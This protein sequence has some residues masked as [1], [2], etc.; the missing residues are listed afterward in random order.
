MRLSLVVA[1]ARNGVI[2]REGQLPWRLPAD[3]RYFRRLT[4]GHPVVM[5][6]ITHESI[7]RALP[8][9]RNVV[10]TRDASRVA[11]GCESAHSLV[12]ALYLLREVPEVM[13][14]GGRALYAEALPRADRLY[15]TEVQ[16]AV[17]GDV[18]FPDFD[19]AAF[20]EISREEHAPEAG[21]DYP[22]TFLTLERIGADDA[23]R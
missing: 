15:L 11:E 17:E 9:R 1:V 12:D 16:A 13:I 18:Y 5:G 20:R 8:G 6:R 19:R 22:C 3:L 7:G 23:P 14:I 4:L 10:V 2:G 21:D